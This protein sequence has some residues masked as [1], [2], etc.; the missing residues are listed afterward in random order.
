MVF[1]PWRI[2][3]KAT[4]AMEMDDRR[5]G[6]CVQQSTVV[7]GQECFNVGSLDLDFKEP[8]KTDEHGNTFGFRTKVKNS[9]GQ[10][11]G[12]WARDVNLTVNPPPQ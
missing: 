9:Q 10:H 11:L 6:F 8:K 3:I 7:A 12:R 1:L 2:S 5:A 4:V